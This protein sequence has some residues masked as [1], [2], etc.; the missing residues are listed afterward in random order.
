MA[1]LTLYGQTGVWL[2]MIFAEV[3]GGVATWIYIRYKCAHSDKKLSDVYLNKISVVSRR[4][5]R[6]PQ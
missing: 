5:K 2:A 3:A 1:V 4:E 6:L